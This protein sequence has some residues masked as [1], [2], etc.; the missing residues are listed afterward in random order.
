MCLDC[1]Y[2]SYFAQ[3]DDRAPLFYRCSSLVTWNLADDDFYFLSYSIYSLSSIWTSHTSNSTISSKSHRSL[4]NHRPP[5]SV[6]SC[7][8]FAP[9]QASTC[10][11][12]YSMILWKT[13]NKCARPSGSSVSSEC[14]VACL[15]PS[16]D[17]CRLYG[18]GMI[19]ECCFCLWCW[20][21]GL[22]LLHEPHHPDLRHLTRHLP[23]QEVDSRSS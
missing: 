20:G 2:L 11:S 17:S 21:R 7:P 19:Y 5:E 23:A 22:V 3:V 9:N 15:H 8:F 12:C 18:Y 16:S 1:R 13:A 10:V 6:T 14:Q 4:A